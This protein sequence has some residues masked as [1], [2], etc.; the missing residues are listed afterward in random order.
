MANL[1]LKFYCLVCLSGV[2][3]TRLEVRHLCVS[4]RW[5]DESNF[6]CL[7]DCSIQKSTQ[8]T[9]ESWICIWFL[10][11]ARDTWIR[12][13]VLVYAFA[14]DVFD[15][16][17]FLSF[18]WC[19]SQAGLSSIHPTSHPDAQIWVLL[20]RP[21]SQIQSSKRILEPCSTTTIHLPNSSSKPISL[22]RGFQKHLANGPCYFSADWKLATSSIALDIP[23]K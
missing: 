11:T 7:V 13:L 8:I 12:N 5:L 23:V 21:L 16:L 10:T 18:L 3:T 19:R 9:M 22:I 17:P 2:A 20:P 4:D 14:E 1:D 6:S 15:E